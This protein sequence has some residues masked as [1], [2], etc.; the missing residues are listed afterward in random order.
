MPVQQ[1]KEAREEE[2]QVREELGGPRGGQGQ[3]PVSNEDHDD[4]EDGRRWRG[5]TRGLW[6]WWSS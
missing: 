4:K 3:S 5:R 2:E 1:T 6:G